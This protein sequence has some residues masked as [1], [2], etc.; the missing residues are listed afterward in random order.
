MKRNKKWIS[1]ILI[2]LLLVSIGALAACGGG[3]S[4]LPNNQ[5]IEDSEDDGDLEEGQGQDG[6]DDQASQEGP[7]GGN[8]DSK[9]LKALSAKA[10]SIKSFSY[11]GVYT[12]TNGEEF[13][14]NMWIKDQKIRSEMID[15]DSDELMVSLIDATSKSMYIYYPDTNYAMKMEVDY[16]VLEDT[17]TLENFYKS[18]VI[19]ESDYLRDETFDGKKCAVYQ[20]KDFEGY[21]A[22]IWIWKEWGLPIKI[23]SDMGS[24]TMTVEFKNLELNKVKDS[25]FELPAG[26]ELI[27]LSGAMG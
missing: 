25:I 13:V 1:L 27:D 26:V 4:D 10:A 5:D 12:F 23:V 2:A 19:D 22:T 14:N 18:A 3:E 6:Q 16:G 24:D 17:M 7:G 20:G 11:E 15:S 8:I 21:T 9:D